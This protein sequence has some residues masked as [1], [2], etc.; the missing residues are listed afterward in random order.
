MSHS[1]CGGGDLNISSTSPHFGAPPDPGQARPASRDQRE[2]IQAVKAV[3]Q[4]ELFGQNELTFVFDPKTRRTVVRIVNRETREVVD[5]IPE[6]YV[7]NLA[8][9]IKGR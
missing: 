5:Q 1:S 2:L 7:L 8:D 3:N 6:E 9:E 4:A